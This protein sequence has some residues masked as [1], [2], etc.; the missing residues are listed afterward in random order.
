MDRYGVGEPEGQVGEIIG[1]N[2]LDF[3]AELFSFF[4]IHFHANLIG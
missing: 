2:F 1:Q 3:A 4:L